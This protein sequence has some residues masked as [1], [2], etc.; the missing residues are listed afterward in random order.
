MIITSRH[1]IRGAFCF[2]V[3]AVVSE[4]I[5]V[6]FGISF[7]DDANHGDTLDIYIHDEHMGASD[8]PNR[9]VDLDPEDETR[10]PIIVWWMPFTGYSRVVHECGT[11][12]CLF[13]HSRREVVNPL[14]EAV[15]FY[16]SGIDWKD[17]PL[18]RRPDHL[19]NLI[20]EESPKNDYILAAPDA[21]ALFNYT[22]TAS[23]HSTYPLVT[24]YLES[25]DS[26]LTPVKYPPSDKSRDGL[27]L[28]MYLHSD[29]G[30]PSDRDSY[31]RVL[32][33]YVQVDSYGKCVNN[34]VLPEHLRDPVQSMDSPDL[35][36]LIGKYKFILTIE[37]AICEDY[38][39]EKLWRSFKAGSVPI[40]KGSPSIRD[41][42]PSNHSVILIDDF[43]SP[44]QLAEYLKYLDENDEE[45]NKYFEYKNHG[46]TNELLID[47]MTE[48]EWF[49]NDETGMKLNFIHGF[50][51]HV[52]DNIHKRRMAQEAGTPLPL[53]IANRTHYNYSDISS[54][55]RI[56]S[57]SEQYKYPG[58]DELSSWKYMYECGLVKAKEIASIVHNGGSSKDIGALLSKDICRNNVSIPKN[59]LVTEE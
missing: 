32:M 1:I 3:F 39:T 19:W 49:V 46:V 52:C 9:I 31:A 35:Y 20:H 48:R 45:Y 27:G 23:R 5:L 28:V 14:T 15:M 17:L 36:D 44:W 47:H 59:W 29:C 22:A 30:V 11:G 4:F 8:T 53:Q 25:I 6:Y 7:H 42:L 56:S 33:K 37:N 41:W 40:Y 34:K 43:E 2:I 57:I 54:I 55:I 16:G 58:F 51:C 50:E 18:P 24:Q 26:I 13:T 38:I 21:M 10:Y 12:S